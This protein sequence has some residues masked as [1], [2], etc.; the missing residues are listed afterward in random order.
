[1]PKESMV[2][3]Y[4]V[5]KLLPASEVPKSHYF[6]QTDACKGLFDVHVK[7][8]KSETEAAIEVLAVITK[9]EDNT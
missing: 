6:P 1:M 7:M 5:K 9:T 2:W 3:D 8:G 4:A